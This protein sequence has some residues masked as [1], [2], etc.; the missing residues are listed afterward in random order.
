MSI[1]DLYDDDDMANPYNVDSRSDI[2]MMAWM[3]KPMTWM[4]NTMKYIE[5]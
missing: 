3:K 2:W 1:A 5:R 4:K